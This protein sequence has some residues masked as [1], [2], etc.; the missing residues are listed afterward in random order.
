MVGRC[1]CALTEVQDLDSE[2]ED[3]SEG[4][5]GYP[6]LLALSVPIPPPPTQFHPKPLIEEH[7]HAHSCA[8]QWLS[9]LKSVTAVA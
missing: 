4:L 1:V 2:G 5:L 7:S 6:K 3:W 8:L 9:T